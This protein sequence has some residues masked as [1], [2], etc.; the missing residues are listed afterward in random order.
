[1]PTYD[2]LLVAKQFHANVHVC[3]ET[4]FGS[5]DPIPLN[6]SSD[7]KT[8][9]AGYVGS[10]YKPG[11]IILLA[12]NP[13]G[14]GDS[15]TQRSAEDQSLYP[16]LTAFKEADE[17]TCLEEFEA[18]NSVLE[19]AIRSWNLRRIMGPVLAAVGASLS[20]I[21][22]MNAV[23][24][25]T[26]GD[27]EPNVMAKSAAWQHVMAP[28]LDVLRPGMVIALGKKAG[29]CIERFYTGSAKIWVVPRTIGDSRISPEAQE[30]LRQI[31]SYRL[32]II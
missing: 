2:R 23:P 3:R 17:E 21:C 7:A 12:I 9:F 15:Y 14:G 27:K 16:L 31:Q 11:G 6:L 5:A 24:Y 1:M 20:S 10:E 22:Y 19:K 28:T 18:I 30:V 4:I 25:R 32:E 13:G 8:M 29:S 26:R